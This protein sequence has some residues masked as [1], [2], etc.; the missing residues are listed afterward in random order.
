MILSELIR[1]GRDERILIVCP[2]HV[3]EQM[4]NEMWS[5]FAIPFVRLDSVGPQRVKQKIP[6]NRN[7]FSWYKRVIISMDTLKQDRFSH[8]LHR[9]EWDAV[10]IDE[11]HNVT[12]D[13]TQ[14]N[15]LPEPWHPILTLSFWRPRPRIVATG[16]PSLNSSGCWNLLLSAPMAI[17][18][19]T[20]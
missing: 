17:S 15:R 12:G 9:R 4:Q 6:A 20:T 3:L 1:R 5:R 7:P 18:T 19:R 16:N 13:T 14:N 10:V 2:R 8:D 11:S